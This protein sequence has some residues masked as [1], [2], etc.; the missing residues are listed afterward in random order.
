[1][2]IGKSNGAV[3]TKPDV[4]QTAPAPVAGTLG[5][6]PLET[7][8]TDNRKEAA[9]GNPYE[10]KDRK[11]LVQGITQAVLASPTLASLPITDKA[12]FVKLAKE[13]ALEMIDFVREQSK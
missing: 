10:A 1:M 13:V 4:A 5:K 9:V 2:P 3:A 11:I 6:R 8:A 7:G 12:S